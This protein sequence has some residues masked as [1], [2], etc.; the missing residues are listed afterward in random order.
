MDRS[1]LC[2]QLWLFGCFEWTSAQL[3]WGSAGQTSSWPWFCLISVF[4]GMEAPLWSVSILMMALMQ[5]QRNESLMSSLFS[6]QDCGFFPFSWTLGFVLPVVL[7]R[8]QRA[9]CH[10]GS[11][12]QS[13]V[14]S[15]V[16]AGSGWRE[17]LLPDP[18]SV[19]LL[20][21]VREQTPLVQ[22]RCLLS[23]LSQGIKPDSFYKV[24]VP[25]LKEIIEGCIRMNKDER[26]E[27]ER[28]SWDQHRLH[29]CCIFSSPWNKLFPVFS[30][31][32]KL[33]GTFLVSCLYFSRTTVRP[34]RSIFTLI[35]W[36]W[37]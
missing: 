9:E 5:E 21:S 30:L 27:W 25:E 33:T 4:T 23:L 11:W 1:A 3:A 10:A 7:T 31:H 12:Q 14:S 26:Y 15:E 8:L 34:I 16:Q 35:S 37:I 28:A 19:I 6:V 18:W 22:L 17:S 24:K 36:K 2:L 20:R 29:K 32:N 13:Y